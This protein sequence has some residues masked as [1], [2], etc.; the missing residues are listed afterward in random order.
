MTSVPESHESS[1]V[2]V[3][4][5]KTIFVHRLWEQ[6]IGWASFCRHQDTL[7]EELARRTFSQFITLVSWFISVKQRRH[8]HAH[9]STHARTQTVS[10]IRPGSCK[11]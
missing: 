2:Q 11:T 9:G 5:F 1:S 10:L 8:T 3:M 7:D 6:H 4:F